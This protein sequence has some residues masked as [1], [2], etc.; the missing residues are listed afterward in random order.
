MG[1]N[2][3]TLTPYRGSEPYIFISYS[4]RNS[5]KAE[6]IISHMNRAGF[7]V[8]Y[9]EGL[10]PGREWDENI[11][12]IIMGCSFFVAL[13]S[14]EYLASSNC[15]DEL[16]FAR[17]KD[18][19]ILLIYLEDVVLPAGMELR[20]GRIF[21]V[22]CSRYSSEEAFYA[23]VF[24]AEGI[25]R[26]NRRYR[27]DST[28]RVSSKTASS[29]QVSRQ[30]LVREV[31]P[32]ADEPGS[33]ALHVLGVVLLILLLLGAAWLLYRSFLPKPPQP[34]VVTTPAIQTPVPTASNEAELDIEVTPSPDPSIIIVPEEEPEIPDDSS[35]PEPT[36]EIVDDFT[37]APIPEITADPTPEPTPVPTPVPT[38]SPV[39]ETDPPF[40]PFPE[41]EPDN[42]ETVVIVDPNT[43]NYF[44]D[45]TDEMTEDTALD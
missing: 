39:E 34:Q 4:H 30:P 28:P 27:P 31:E 9:D 16:N 40:I 36:Q 7:R 13:L 35:T 12:R 38:S 26:C 29:R 8:W 15:K 2:D 17:D 41:E 6:E 25:T 43:D 11:A 42:P 19:P 33:S 37:P 3:Q 23:K 24:A 45:N 14:K 22:H 44:Q 5:G 18:K 21:A 1:F 32:D 20:L 10:I